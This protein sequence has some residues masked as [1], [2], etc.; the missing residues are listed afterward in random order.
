M[1]YRK[2]VI[3]MKTLEDIDVYP[4]APRDIKEVTLCKGGGG[5]A[6]KVSYPN[7]ISG[8]HGGLLYHQSMEANLP[9]GY[10]AP[11]MSLMEAMNNAWSDNPYTGVTVYDP[12]SRLTDAWGVIDDYETLVDAL[13]DT[14]DWAA[15]FTQA[16]S[17][18]HFNVWR[19]IYPNASFVVPHRKLP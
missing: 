1:F 16:N 17:L 19:I 13:D 9:S 6:G 8:I 4:V 10:V 11:N 2:V 12:S 18:E 7:Y 14:T 15:F 3:D 5:S